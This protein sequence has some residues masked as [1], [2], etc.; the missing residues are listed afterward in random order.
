MVIDKHEHEPAENVRW[1]DIK[2][3]TNTNTIGSENPNIDRGPEYIA[4]LQAGLEETLSKP[5]KGT[6]VTDLVLCRRLRVFRE[7]NPLP[8]DAKTLAIFATGIAFH[9]VYQWLLYTATAGGSNERST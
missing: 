4:R 6:H 3:S 5:R 2:E 8:I 7:I 1:N 9:G